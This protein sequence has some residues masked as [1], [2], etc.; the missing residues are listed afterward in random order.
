MNC[1]VSD[2]NEFLMRIAG[3]SCME[4]VRRMRCELGGIRSF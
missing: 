4:F 3:C 2:C 1:E